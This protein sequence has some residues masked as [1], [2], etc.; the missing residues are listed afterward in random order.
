MYVTVDTLTFSNIQYKTL[1]VYVYFPGNDNIKLSFPIA[2]TVTVLAWGYHVWGEAYQNHGMVEKFKETLRWPL[3]YLLKTYNNET[4]VLFT[5][6][7]VQLAIEL[8]QLSFTS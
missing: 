8:F 2:S 1:I 4:E 5:M 7:R 6:V 3:N